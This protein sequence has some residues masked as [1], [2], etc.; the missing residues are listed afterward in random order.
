VRIHTTSFGA[1]V[2]APSIFAGQALRKD[3]ILDR[4][5]NGCRLDMTLRPTHHLYGDFGYAGTSFVGD[6]HGAVEGVPSAPLLEQVLAAQRRCVGCLGRVFDVHF[7]VC[8]RRYF[9]GGQRIVMLALGTT[10][11]PTNHGNLE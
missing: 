11:R 6:P 4:H 7:Q 3:L 1:F 9:V 2:A 5:F 8:T 10:M